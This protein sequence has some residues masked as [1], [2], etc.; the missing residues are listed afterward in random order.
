MRTCA[1]P[2]FSIHFYL[3]KW[4]FNSF[5]NQR[6]N[7]RDKKLSSYKFF[8]RSRLS[9]SQN[10]IYLRN[11]HAII[12]GLM[13][14]GPNWSEDLAFYITT[15]SKLK[16]RNKA[17]HR[18]IWGDSGSIQDLS[19]KRKSKVN[20]FRHECLHS[21]DGRECLSI[22]KLGKS[23]TNYKLPNDNINNGVSAK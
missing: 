4:S 9:C 22:V 15:K 11:F 14:R 10:C 3:I 16:S 2:L 8:F 5:F 18:N 1:R 23:M 17:W 7:H 21:K 19:H 20:L 12:Q 6:R 13:L